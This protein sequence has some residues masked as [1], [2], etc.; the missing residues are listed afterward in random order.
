MDGFNGPDETCLVFVDRKGQT[1]PFEPFNKGTKFREN[2][3]VL[4]PSGGGM[5]FGLNETIERATAAGS[6]VRII[7]DGGSYMQEIPFFLTGRTP[8]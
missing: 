5:S 6:A 3:F 7:D 8:T 1:I 2:R 4:A